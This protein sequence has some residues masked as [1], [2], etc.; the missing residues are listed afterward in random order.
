M[1]PLAGHVNPAL[2][3]LQNGL[4]GEDVL[5]IRYGLIRS[6][7]NRSFS[8]EPLVSFFLVLL[9]TTCNY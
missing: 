1:P 7:R 9:C 4:G 8:S 3:G 2:I 6:S 5:N